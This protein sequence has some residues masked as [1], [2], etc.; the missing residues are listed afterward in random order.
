MLYI[1]ICVCVCFIFTHVHPL[2]VPGHSVSF[3]WG[4][5]RVGILLRRLFQRELHTRGRPG[6]SA[7]WT[8]TQDIVPCQSLIRRYMIVKHGHSHVVA[9]S[10]RSN[11]CLQLSFGVMGFYPYRI[12]S[13]PLFWAILLVEA[14]LPLSKSV[15]ADSFFGRS[16]VGDEPAFSVPKAKLI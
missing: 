5:A 1:Y 4:F 6:T 14:M 10:C 13:D 12:T 8:W 11:S 7:S 16:K 15:A 9:V 2:H 3:Y